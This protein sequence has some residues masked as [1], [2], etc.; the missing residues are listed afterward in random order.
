VSP[1]DTMR[2]GIFASLRANRAGK[3]RKRTEPRAVVVVD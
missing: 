1:V 3:L 2:S